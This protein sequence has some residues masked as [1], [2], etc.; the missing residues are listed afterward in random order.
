LL[1]RE[2]PPPLR[3]PP[4]APP[5]R[6]PPCLLRCG[7]HQNEWTRGPEEVRGDKADTYEGR[8]SG[9][10]SWSIAV[11]IRGFYLYAIKKDGF[12]LCAIKKFSRACVPSTRTSL[13]STP[14]RPLFQLTVSN[15]LV[16]DQLTPVGLLTVNNCIKVRS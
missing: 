1:H 11:K 13:T 3:A 4:R 5:L 2:L 15:R 8:G 10:P 14:F 9:G 7:L 6:P 16:N 12:D